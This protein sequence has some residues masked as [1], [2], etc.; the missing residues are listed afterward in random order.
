MSD[1]RITDLTEALSVAASDLTVVVT[2]P[3]TTPETK[4]I[5]ISNLESSLSIPTPSNTVVAQLASGMSSTPGILTTYSRG[6]HTH[7]TPPG[8]ALTKTDDTNVTLTLGGTPTSA[9]LQPASLTLGWTGQLAV[10]RGGTGLASWTQYGIVYAPTTGSLGQLALGTTTQVL[11]GNAT[12]AAT[13]GS[14]VEADL[15]L[16]DLTTADVSTSAHGF[17]P[18]ATAPAASVRTAL[19]ID[20]SETL[21]TFK[22]TLDSTNPTTIGIGDAAAPGTALIYAHRDHQHASPSTWTATAHNILSSQHGDTLADSVVRGDLLY[23]NATPQ[24]ARLAKGAAGTY[25]TWDANDLTVSKVVITQPATSATLT[26]ADGKTLTVNNTLTVAASADGYTVTFPLTVAQTNAITTS[27]D[28]SAGGTAILASNA[29]ALT[30]KSLVATQG[31]TINS[32]YKASWK[33]GAT[34]IGYCMVG[35]DGIGAITGAFG[36]IGS[37]AYS[38]ALNQ[39]FSYYNGATQKIIWALS[40]VAAS[41]YANLYK[42]AG[43]FAGLRIGDATAPTGYLDI[44]GKFIVDSNGNPTKVNNV[45]TSFPA[46][47]G[48]ANSVLANDGSGNLS[49]TGFLLTGTTGG[50][51]NFAVTNTKTLTLTA[52]D[53]FNLTIPA[54]GTVAIG[55]GTLT[56]ATTNNVTGSAHTHAITSSSNPGA[57]AN[58]LAT[59]SAGKLTTVLLSTGST[60]ANDKILVYENG[61]QKIG[62]GVSGGQFRFFTNVSTTD[63]VFYDSDAGNELYRMKGNGLIG[64]GT[65][66]P[67]CKFHIQYSGTATAF[68]QGSLAFGV[69]SVSDIYTAWRNNTS[70]LEGVLG[71]STPNTSMIFGGKAGLSLQM[72]ANNAVGATLLQSTM[73][74]GIGVSPTTRLHVLNDSTSA[75][76]ITHTTLTHTGSGANGD[77]ASILMAG[78]SST[79][80]AQSMAMLS[81]E[82]INSTHAS[83]TAKGKLIA[84]DTA[85][86]EAISWGANGSAATLALFGVALTAQPTGDLFAGMVN[87][88]TNASPLVPYGSMYADDVTQT[89]TISATATY[90]EVP[91]SLSDGGSSASFTFQSSKQLLCNTAG[92]Y[93]VTWGM[94]LQCASANQE[95]TGAVMVNTTAKTNTE[96]ATKLTTG[97]NN[98]LVAGTGI[99][100]LA[101]NDVVKLCVENETGTNDIIVTHATL[102]LSKLSN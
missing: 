60:V 78:K 59:D 21:P 63:Y 10:A 50:T 19:V 85:A 82:W 1:K 55:A 56:V 5:Q 27:N 22:V 35:D 89:V 47:Q 86:R 16:T 83:R 69:Q 8:Q 9:L 79:T 80:A 68:A 20:N 98:K 70:A 51:T 33:S 48:A 72:L 6:D 24:W 58:L 65:N 99:I 28:V 4:K 91:G 32:G 17:A 101:V 96:G 23:G 12:G 42:T 54:T 15:G 67:Q 97:N 71:I 74:F 26:I 39:M 13:F 53:N 40:A 81:W 7:G 52:T 100:T 90:Y 95:V 37:A 44:V 46:S 76:I 3:G 49:W 94:T 43:T 11:H 25:P 77:G 64:I 87:L 45:V 93:R 38:N 84:Y 62:F 36:I 73:N 88:G 31:L 61:A 30:L 14:V 34:E 29:G 18:K 2:N 102:S 41:N 75:G 92:T 66:N 57:A